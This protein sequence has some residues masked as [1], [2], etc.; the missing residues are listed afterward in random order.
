M[1]QYFSL[2]K[3]MVE[4]NPSCLKPEAHGLSYYSLGHNGQVEYDIV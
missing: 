2:I 4:L 1:A 3:P